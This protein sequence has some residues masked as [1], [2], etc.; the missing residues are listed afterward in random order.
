MAEVHVH[1]HEYPPDVLK[2]DEAAFLLGVKE[3]AFRELCRTY[4]DRLRAFNLLP[5]GQRLWSRDDVLAFRDWRRT[6]GV[7][8]RAG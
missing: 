8:P 4:P 1:A 5:G 3:T 6:V 2:A 7:E